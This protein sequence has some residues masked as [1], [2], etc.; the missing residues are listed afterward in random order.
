V[1]LAFR[2]LR[3]RRAWKATEYPGIKAR[4]AEDGVWF[5]V[6]RALQRH[7]IQYRCVVGA[8]VYTW[9]ATAE[10]GRQY[11]YTGGR[12]N[13]V[14]VLAVVPPDAN[15]NRLAAPPAQPGRRATGNPLVADDTQDDDDES[16]NFS[17][18]PSA[19]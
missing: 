17:G 13:S 5:D 6:P 4:L 2:R 15:G 7:G 18:Y 3:D 14:E 11:V 19:Y 1:V 10:G 16:S 9:E 8:G 12:P